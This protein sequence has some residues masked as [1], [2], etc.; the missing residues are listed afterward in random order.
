MMELGQRYL[1]EIN[2]DTVTRGGGGMVDLDPM[3]Q[4]GVPCAGLTVADG[5][6]ADKTDIYFNFHHTKADTITAVRPDEVALC[7]ASMAAW[8]YAVADLDTMLPRS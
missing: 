8:S 3:C 6:R 5:S 1:S 4:V 2:A 7:V